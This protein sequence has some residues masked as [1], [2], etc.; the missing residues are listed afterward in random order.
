[1]T[2]IITMGEMMLRLTPPDN[3]RLEQ[4]QS[5]NIF[6]GGDEANVAVSLSIFGLD[7]AFITKLP[8]NPFGQEAINQLK[9]FGI[10]T[11]FIKKGG[12]RIGINFYEIGAAMRPSRVIYD[13]TNSAISDASPDDFDFD[14]IFDNATWF[15]TSGITPALSEKTEKITKIA[16]KKAK[17]KGL[18]VSMDLNYRK[19]LW[20]PEKAKSVMT[21][22]MQYV[23]VCIG[24]EEDTE[25]V[26]GFVPKNT[27]INKGE[28]NLDG[29]RDIF[30]EM[31]TRFDFKI[32]GTTLRE[33]YSASDNGWSALVYDGK[34]FYHSKKYNIHLV[35]RGGGG[36]AFAAGLIYGLVKEM[37]LGETVEFAAAASALKQ[38]ILGDFNLITRE[39]VMNLAT[40]DASG[41]IQR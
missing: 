31:K 24:N 23:D 27:D 38:T 39:E 13:R 40:G 7:V 4:T 41:R 6:Y 15:H 19:K 14:E 12:Q 11:D 17:E 35:D 10:N 21:D 18:T 16:L 3:L 5:F 30:K 2:N 37:P 32:I 20:S 8:Q 26:L 36:C 33:S 1:M 25:K 28:L 9:K 29:Y 34:Q 22:L